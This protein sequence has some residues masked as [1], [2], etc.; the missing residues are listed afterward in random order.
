MVRAW[1]F[2]AMIALGLSAGPLA[3]SVRLGM[4]FARTPPARPKGQAPALQQ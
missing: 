4:P 1:I 3:R 2:A